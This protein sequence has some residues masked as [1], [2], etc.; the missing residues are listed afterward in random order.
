LTEKKHGL[1]LLL[2]TTRQALGLII[3]VKYTR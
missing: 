2:L 3:I 1:V